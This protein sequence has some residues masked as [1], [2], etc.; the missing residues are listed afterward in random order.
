MKF[1]K[2]NIIIIILSIIVIIQGIC[3][4]ELYQRINGIIG[5]L[6]NNGIRMNDIIERNNLDTKDYFFLINQDS[7]QELLTKETGLIIPN[8]WEISYTKIKRYTNEKSQSEFTL[9]ID[10]D[11]KLT[12]DEVADTLYSKALSLS[13]YDM[14]LRSFD[15]VKK[16][17]DINSFS[18]ATYNNMYYDY[19][20]DYDNEGRTTS[21]NLIKL[22]LLH[23]KDKNQAKLEV[24][25]Y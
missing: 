9:I 8:N 7:W 3:I 4:N 25:N 14:P 10:L 17:Y 1:I 22:K 13:E 11:D 5:G 12:F 16:F 19:P 23:L 20:T 18:E 24:N 15:D 2:K 21:T 6:I